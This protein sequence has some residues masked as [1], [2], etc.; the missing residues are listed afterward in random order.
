MVCVWLNQNQY[1]RCGMNSTG[2][3]A[4]YI[5]MNI[6][7]LSGAKSRQLT[8]FLG[9]QRF[10]AIMLFACA[11]GCIGLIFTRSPYLSILCIAIVACTRALFVPLV[12]SLLNRSITDENRATHLSTFALLQ[13]SSAALAQAL[14]GRAA[15]ASLNAA[16]VLCALACIAVW[17]AFRNFYPNT[18]K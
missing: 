2:I 9:G 5:L 17:I 18:A 7:M 14:Y 4:A 10:G 8:D 11:A 12:R 6:A 3:G 16:F 1:L 13:S 15:D